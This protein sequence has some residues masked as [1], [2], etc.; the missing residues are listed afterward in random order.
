VPKPG[1]ASAPSSYLLSSA[2]GKP[3]GN[4]AMD[5]HR[6]PGKPAQAIAAGHWGRSASLGNADEHW[7]PVAA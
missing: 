5:T 6:R 3:L 1:S 2:A 4:L 7:Q